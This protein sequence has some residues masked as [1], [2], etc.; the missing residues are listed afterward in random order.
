VAVC[1]N[2][3]NNVRILLSM[4]LLLLPACNTYIFN[5]FI[6]IKCKLPLA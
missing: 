3:H 2:M 1:L 5:V 4:V 6:D